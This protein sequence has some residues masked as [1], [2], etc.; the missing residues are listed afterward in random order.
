M[1]GPQIPYIKVPEIPLPFGDALPDAMQT[2]KPFGLLVAT[3]VYLGAWVAMRRGRQRGLDEVNVFDPVSGK[4]SPMR[5][6][7]YSPQCGDAP[8]VI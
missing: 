6:K 1:P 8:F 5:I 3:G 4:V 2:I 7:Y